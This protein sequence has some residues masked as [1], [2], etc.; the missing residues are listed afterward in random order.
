MTIK[1]RRLHGYD[2]ALSMVTATGFSSSS[3][4]RLD[5]VL[6][7]VGILDMQMN[8]GYRGDSVR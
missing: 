4:V 6:V 2:F 5:I 7:A 1:V 3:S 8:E